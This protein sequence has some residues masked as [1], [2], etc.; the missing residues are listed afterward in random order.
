M[1]APSPLKD[2]L[3]K[4]TSLSELPEREAGRL[5]GYQKHS[6]KHG[7]TNMEELDVREM[8]ALR[9]GCKHHH[10]GTHV[11]NGTIQQTNSQGLLTTIQHPASNVIQVNSVTV[12]QDSGSAVIT[13]VNS[14]EF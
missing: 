13:Q 8:T 2:P 4:S 9:G 3:L 5:A 11:Q 7:G 14:V 10:P 6:Y 12:T 1:K